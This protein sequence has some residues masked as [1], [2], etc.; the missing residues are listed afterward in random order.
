MTKVGVGNRPRMWEWVYGNVVKALRV[1]WEWAYRNVVTALGMGFD[2][3]A[4]RYHSLALCPQQSWE[5]FVQQNS[6]GRILH[7][8]SGGSY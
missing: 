2:W 8:W 3:H 4:H 1:T 5:C 6:P 7:H